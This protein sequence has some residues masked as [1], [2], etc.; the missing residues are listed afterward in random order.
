MNY[1]DRTGTILL[2][3]VKGIGCQILID[4]L[5]ETEKE[6]VSGDLFGVELIVKL[7]HYVRLKTLLR[8]RYLDPISVEGRVFNA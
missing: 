7:V 3:N 8:K 1:F 6:P 2:P 5:V 4:P